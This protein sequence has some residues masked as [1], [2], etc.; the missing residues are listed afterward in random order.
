MAANKKLIKDLKV[1]VTQKGVKEVGQE[2]GSLGT[3][4]SKANTA[5]QTLMETFTK[6]PQ[7]LKTV[8]VNA[9]AVSNVFIAINNNIRKA[10][11]AL[12]GINNIKLS[13]ANTDKFADNLL[14]SSTSIQAFKDA[15]GELPKIIKEM[16]GDMKMLSTG[17][18]NMSG[19]TKN[20]GKLTGIKFDNISKA[21][22]LV[23]NL[24][25][26]LRNVSRASG[27]SYDSMSRFSSMGSGDLS[28]LTNLAKS[29]EGFN[30]VK[31]PSFKTQAN[32]LGTISQELAKIS[33]ELE[34]AGIAGSYLE[35]SFT[36]MIAQAQVLT[37]E[38]VKI[39][40]PEVKG[41]DK[42]IDQMEEL[43]NIVDR[44]AIEMGI[45]M[46]AST[47]ALV[48][49]L[50][51]VSAN[52]SKTATQTGR[53][54]QKLNEFNKTGEQ[55]QKM[56][57]RVAKSGGAVGKSFS[58]LAKFAGPL[59][60]LYAVIFA[61]LY[62]LNTVY[63]G[64]ASGD[65]L[66]RLEQLSSV[67]GAT[68]GVN[69][70][71]AA[72]AMQDLAGGAIS[73]EDA[74][75]Q[76]TRGAGYGFTT[77]D[78]EQ[79]TLVARRAAVVLGVDMV[80][81]MDRV[82]R[83]VSKQE[84]EILDELGITIRLNEAYA[85]T[86]QQ[87]NKNANDL[88]SYQK[89]HSY[90]QAVVAQSTMRFGEFDKAL[91]ANTYERLG[92]NIKSLGLSFLQLS[93]NVLRPV[94]DT[95][96]KIV[97]ALENTDYTAAK[98]V[99]TIDTIIEAWNEAKKGTNVVSKAGLGS[100]LVDNSK[101]TLD[102][103]TEYKDKVKTLST[104]LDTARAKY[105][106]LQQVA[107]G[108]QSKNPYISGLGSN[109]ASGS[110]VGA[111]YTTNSINTEIIDKT[112]ELMDAQKSVENLS[113]KVEEL[114][115]N[116]QDAFNEFGLSGSHAQDTFEQLAEELRG[117]S[118]AI[119]NGSGDMQ[120]AFSS[121]NTTLTPA[122]QIY[123]TIKGINDQADSLAA[124]IPKIGRNKL[125]VTNEIKK[126]YKALNMSESAARNLQKVFKDSAAWDAL[127]SHRTL[128]TA[129]L[130]LGQVGQGGYS[131]AK[132]M[133]VTKKQI[134]EATVSVKNLKDQLEGLRASNSLSKDVE[135]GLNSQ[136][137]ETSTSLVQLQKNYVDQQNTLKSQKTDTA[138]Y[139]SQ[140]AT[141]E[142]QLRR[143]ATPLDAITSANN[144]LV[145]AQN[146]YADA[147]SSN[148]S[149]DELASKLLA[150]RNAMLQRNMATKEAI[151]YN[152]QLASTTSQLN[153]LQTTEASKYAGK[154]IGEITTE[155][156]ANVIK[157]GAEYVSLTKEA[158]DRAK[159]EK[160]SNV[161]LYDTQSKLDLQLK[162][163]EA[164][165]SY[166]QAI[167]D[168]AENEYSLLQKYNE[169]YSYRT[170]LMETDSEAATRSYKEQLAYVNK[171]EAINAVH[172]T[173]LGGNAISDEVMNNAKTELEKLKQAAEQAKLDRE[174]QN[175]G[176]VNGAMN[177]Y[178]YTD[179]RGMGAD[180]Q[181]IAM[182]GQGMQDINNVFS[183]LSSYNEEM[184]TMIGNLNG[185]ANGFVAMGQGA[186]NGLQV[187]SA[188][189]QSLS[190]IIQF[191][192]S[193]TMSSIQ[194]QIDA[195]KSRDG[196][197]AESVAKINKLETKR[198]EVQKKSA[199]ASIAI[200]TAQGI[201]MAMGTLPYPY[202]LVQAGAVAL[203]GAM[204]YQQ[205]MS[206]KP[207][208][209]QVDS[210]VESLTLGSR[211]NTVDVSKAANAGELSYIQGNRGSGS[212]QNFT[213]RAEGGNVTPGVG[214]IVG[215]KG[216]EPFYPSVA[217]TIGS[218]SSSS[219]SSSSTNIFQIHAIDSKSFEELVMNNPGLFTKAV[220]R[221]MNEKGKSIIR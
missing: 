119:K 135:K 72:L 208:L 127:A 151:D 110:F 7:T 83:G 19:A 155:S 202:N 40:V 160:Q 168:N 87:L 16:S 39:N 104:E 31:L 140:L 120:K 215:E 144:D 149:T 179:I 212:I 194:D 96:N 206:A 111:S 38:T 70:K 57:N 53:L 207:N 196:K 44:L 76:A 55:Q 108:T 100:E 148:K 105:L 92:A 52:A 9:N 54:N 90:L 30:N 61:N 59:P 199:A 217:G 73:Y 142:V 115:K 97:M 193:Q 186:T 84:I 98:T 65:R 221:D 165:A 204:A 133:E 113:A 23:N 182:M 138:Y 163:M 112:K 190:S 141:T 49:G 78:L 82:V 94:A 67:F 210:G 147:V 50:D 29:L 75:T 178:Q 86:A 125:E 191:S 220:E 36:R 109:N 15:L 205:A 81:A 24:A 117:T 213:P 189:L 43:L 175:F 157:T 167:S 184:G 74:L 107:Q 8:I 25:E 48:E 201:M 1:T 37:S 180:Q 197:S 41:M 118:L 93:A 28:S 121:M 152:I 95:L 10:N 42:L 13:T 66:N 77:K 32:N 203:M 209:T 137:D 177:G 14:N 60:Q 161:T 33:P 46:K 169:A 166:K 63:E 3:K 150:V 101:D 130:Q 216:P 88:T 183:N 129:Q 181:K 103:I 188:G 102:M 219:N 71:G 158:E 116:A 126:M 18:N 172:K 21:V 139:N 156:V 12:E 132:D 20:L 214:Y 85:K 99:K 170:R 123:T 200:N 134:D 185:L 4:I 154:G 35:D 146:E 171:L 174:K 136:I 159:A 124:L 198:I 173:E 26:A 128:T 164:L 22:P 192:S 62:A 34:K 51:N 153:A 211:S 91:Q 89:Q 143:L 195:E 79:M 80:D 17:L 69:I 2:I 131:S 64:L 114:K 6:L 11:K 145:K 218:N 122:E 5:A 68:M 27:T 176:A 106:A 162:T 56:Q 58:D 187:A 45:E 47:D